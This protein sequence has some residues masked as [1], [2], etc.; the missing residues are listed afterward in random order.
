MCIVY[1]R[2]HHLCNI[3]S[4]PP[5]PDRVALLVL[6][7]RMSLSFVDRIGTDA[8]LVFGSRGRVSRGDRKCTSAR[9][10]ECSGEEH[11]QFGCLDESSPPPHYT[12][13]CVPAVR[14]VDPQPQPGLPSS[15]RA[16]RRQHRLSQSALTRHMGRRDVQRRCTAWSS[17]HRAHRASLRPRLCI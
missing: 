11:P 10:V 1:V 15:H 5:P 12:L 7:L 6:R 17:T 13:E 3:P 4:T 16:S 2:E 14:H 9:C 8:V